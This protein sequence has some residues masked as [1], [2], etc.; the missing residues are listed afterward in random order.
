M[1]TTNKIQAI[2]EE[3]AA[4]P[5]MPKA[6]AINAMIRKIKAMRNMMLSF[7]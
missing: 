5:D 2:S 1:N 4:T 6:P 3:T 7:L